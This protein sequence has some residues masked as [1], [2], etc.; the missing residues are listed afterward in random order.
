MKKDLNYIAGLEKA[1]KEKYGEEAIANPKANWDEQREEEY[2]QQI[3]ERIK[4][5][6]KHDEKLE[7]IE[8]NGVLISK[9]LFNRESTSQPAFVFF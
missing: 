3:E 1:V 5:D 9:K 6:R 7:K 4:K 2:K 8:V